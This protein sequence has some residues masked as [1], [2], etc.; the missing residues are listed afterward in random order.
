MVVKGKAS[1]TI[2]N[3]LQFACVYMYM[4]VCVSI[5]LNQRRETLR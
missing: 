4:Y 2:R 5:E 1:E 3:D